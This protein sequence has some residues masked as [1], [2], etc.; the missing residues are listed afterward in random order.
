MKTRVSRKT[1]HR[2]IHDF[3]HIGRESFDLA[4][5][6]HPDISSVQ[7]VHFAPEILLK[8]LPK[9]LELAFRS[10]P[11]L[12]RERIQGQSFHTE[13]IRLTDDCFDPG[14]AP[15]MPK[16]AAVPTP[17]GPATVAIHDEGDVFGDLNRYGH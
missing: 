14:R 6:M 4:D 15:D 3:T 5:D 17:I 7:L 11:V 12:G 10:I 1:G 16:H 8:Q 2:M 13:T 9:D